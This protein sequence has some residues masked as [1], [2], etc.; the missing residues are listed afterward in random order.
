VFSAHFSVH[1]SFYF[2]HKM[3]TTLIKYVIVPLC[4]TVYSGNQSLQGWFVARNEDESES[5]PMRNWSADCIRLGADSAGWTR[6]Q[7]FRSP[8]SMRKE[9]RKRQSVHYFDSSKIA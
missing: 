4:L 1:M 6:S 5:S 8:W 9:T 7:L 2:G 3:G